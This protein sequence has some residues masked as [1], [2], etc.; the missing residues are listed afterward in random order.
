MTTEI[1]GFVKPGFE[2]VQRAFEKNFA[3]GLERGA[4]VAV[5]KD[6][7]LVVDLELQHVGCCQR[8]QE[9]ACCSAAHVCSAK[10]Q[11]MLPTGSYA[12]TGQL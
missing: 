5:T 8:E 3:E 1:H 11:I 9:P 6:G 7:E 2:P 12:A 10:R 4:S